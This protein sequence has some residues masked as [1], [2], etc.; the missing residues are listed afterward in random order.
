ERLLYDDRAAKEEL[1]T[2]LREIVEEEIENSTKMAALCELNPFLGFQA[3]AE[4]Y[5]YFPGE[6]HWRADRLRD[7][8]ATEMKEAEAAVAAGERVFSEASGLAGE[9]LRYTAPKA[10]AD[11]AANWQQGKTWASVPETSNPTSSPVWRW[12]ATHD[13][14]ALYVNVEAVQSEAWRPVEAIISIEPTHIYPRRTFR[15]TPAGKRDIRTV[16]LGEEMPWDAVGEV[17]DRQQ[18]FRL[19]VPLE[20]FLGQDNLTRPMRINVEVGYLSKDKKRRVVQS[21]VPRST[22]PVMPRLGYGRAN[23]EEMGWLVRE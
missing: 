16:W 21:W 11:F 20:T 12:Q 4:G 22:N 23:P 9:S 13:D 2:E 5:T 3:E 15:I 1:I 10:A 17:V 19:R 6:L 18:S 8:L 7:L 14:S